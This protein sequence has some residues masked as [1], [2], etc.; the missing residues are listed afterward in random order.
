MNDEYLD[1]VDEKDKVI[2]KKL[3]SEIY[4]EHL[5]NFRVI[6]LFIK[7]IEGQLWIPRRTANKKQFPSALDMSVGGHVES[8]SDYEETL[9]KEAKEELNI[10]IS[11][12]DYKFLGKMSPQEH[13]VSAFMSVYEVRINNVPEYNKD[14]FTE[15][16]WLTPK[17]LLK[18]IEDGDKAK[19]DLL[20]I[21]KHFYLR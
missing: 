17:Q 14:D 2:G 3:R 19:S 18:T 15:Y 7:N 11:N 5:N 6:N 4:A 13:G 21:V 9:K 12:F 20:K 16:Y 1:L 8:G 10:D